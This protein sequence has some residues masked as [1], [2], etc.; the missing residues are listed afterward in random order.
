VQALAGALAGGVARVFVA[1]LDVIKIRFQ[2]Q[3]EPMRSGLGKYTGLRQAATLIV[4]EEGLRGLWRG[5]APA[6]LLWVP[7]TALQFAALARINAACEAAG[8]RHDKPPMSF[9]GGAAA[10]AAA[11]LCTYPLDL[12]RTLM[13]AQGVPPVYATVADAARGTVAA[14][15]PVGLFAGL[16]FTVRYV[17]RFVPILSSPLT[18]C[19]LAC[20]SRPAPGARG[21]CWRSS[22][23]RR[24][25]SARTLHSSLQSHRGAPRMPPLPAARP[26]TRTA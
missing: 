14:R 18:A 16:S 24:C 9:V 15:G 26:S 8:V 7:Y 17:A 6:L 4:K 23:T 5:T 25:S 1:P 21:S 12:L 19:M 20:C 13:A 3:V 22:R 2:V 11:T 10:A